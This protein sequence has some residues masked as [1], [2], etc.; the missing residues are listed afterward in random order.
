[1]AYLPD[2]TSSF[3]ELN[4]LIGYIMDPYARTN[5]PEFEMSSEEAWEQFKNVS[6]HI[7]SLVE[8]ELKKLA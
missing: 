5:S 8:V 4:R 3:H 2:S 6:W 1:M 7:Q